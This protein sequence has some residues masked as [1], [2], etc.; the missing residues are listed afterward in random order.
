MPNPTCK[1]CDMDDTYRRIAATGVCTDCMRELGLVEMPPTRRPP[2][3]CMRCNQ[4]RFVRVI[5]REHAVYA[6][7][8]GYTSTSAPMTATFDP[9][10]RAKWLFPGKAIDPRPTVE[11]SHGMYETYICTGCGFVE[12]YCHDV[13]SIPIGPEYMTELVDHEA[14]EPYR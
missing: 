9:E 13:T 2:A 12:W 1:L 7:K 5:P 14:D 6:I 8:G 3:P 10:R 11:R 4:R